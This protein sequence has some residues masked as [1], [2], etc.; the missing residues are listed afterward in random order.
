M[1]KGFFK[2][3]HT[4]T[5]FS[6]FLYF[7][8]SFM[9]W[10][11]LGPLGVHIARD[12]SLGPAQKGMM[13]AIPVLFGAVL[14][15]PLGFLA[16]HIGPKKTG[17]IGQ[18]IVTLALLL[19][20]KFGLHSL[21]QLYVMG[22][23]LGFA[24]ASFAVALPMVCRW[25]PPK[26]QGLAMGI[27]GAGNS[28]TVLSVLFAPRLAEA[29]GW[30]AV[31]GFAAIPMAVTMMIYA[32]LAQDAPERSQDVARDDLLSEL[33][34]YFQVLKETDTW[35]FCLFYSVTFGGFVGL[36]SSLVIYFNDQYGL[37]PVTAGNFTAVCVFIGSMV[38]P[39]GGA[40][41]DRI[42]GISAL[43]ILYIIVLISMFTIGMEL[44]SPYLA[45]AVF[46]L[47]MMG[48]G[49][50]NGAV[51]QLVPL[52]FRNKIGTMT[53]IVGTAG[54]IGGF[55]LASLLGYSREWTGSYQLGFMTFAGLAVVC[56]FVILAVQTRWRT[57]WRAAS[58]AA[59]I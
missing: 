58:A 37:N 49:M 53:G 36:A 11:V 19:A 29:F 31:L 12:L 57:N 14:R 46:A 32:L 3:G 30:Q 10:V 22:V 51:F 41:A 42:G 43:R 26:H 33:K 20:W 50:G 24:G 23:F 4:P 8:I 39:L 52:R 38:R 40:L 25:Y 2:Q 15:I 45:L 48:L 5:L 17:L 16:D 34:K 54:G 7:D 35:W 1:I 27:A 28:G 18:V 55:F 13:V 9:V 44:S 56:L 59:K 21:H 47:G 6:A